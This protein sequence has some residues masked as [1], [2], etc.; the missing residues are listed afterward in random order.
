MAKDVASPIA[1]S[2]LMTVALSMVKISLDF[3][4]FVPD[5]VSDID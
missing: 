5:C 4:E 3:V 2:I 1:L